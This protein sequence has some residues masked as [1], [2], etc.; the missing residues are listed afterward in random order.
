M[1]LGVSQKENQDNQVTN[2][3][4]CSPIGVAFV[5]RPCLSSDSQVHIS[6]PDAA[7]LCAKGRTHLCLDSKPQLSS[8]VGTGDG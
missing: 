2:D 3:R 5:N 4:A 7:A 6:H 1:P 8:E